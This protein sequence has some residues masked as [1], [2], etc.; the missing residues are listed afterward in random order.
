M[1]SK[2]LGAVICELLGDPKWSDRLRDASNKYGNAARTP[3]LDEASKTKL[4]LMSDRARNLALKNR[5]HTKLR[6][7]HLFRNWSKD[8]DHKSDA[9]IKTVNYNILTRKLYPERMKRLLNAPTE[10]QS[11]INAAKA[12]LP[13]SLQK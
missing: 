13:K 2:S 6:K 9:H 4:E 3:E 7:F 10:K 8:W 12:L 11:N 1:I 5:N